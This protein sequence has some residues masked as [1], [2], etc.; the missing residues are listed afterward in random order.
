MSEAA[1]RTAYDE[2]PYPGYTHPQTHPDRLA[3]IATVF[4]MRPK[5]IEGCRVLEL[6]CGDG[7]NLIPMAFGLR[8]SEFVGLD[9][10]PTAIAK[11]RQA[12]EELGLKN[13]QLRAE[14][15]LAFPKEFGRFDYIIAHGLY[16]WVPREVRDA[17]LRICSE[18]L[19]PAGVAFVSYNAFP[20]GHL[21]HMLRDM[22]FFH[23][24][25]ISDSKGRLS[26]AMAL[27]RFMSRA[28]ENNDVYAR[29]LQEE[30]EQLI[31]RSAGHLYH[32]EL[33]SVY[34]PVY[35]HEFVGHAQSHGLQY[36]GEA[37]FMEMQD[38]LFTDETR[39]TLNGL[40]T[41]RIA[42]EQYLDFLKCRRFR[43]TLLC[44]GGV[45]LELE[46]QPLIVKRF[47]LSSVAKPETPEVN[48]TDDSVVK[49]VGKRIAS[50]E[51]NF[52]LAKAALA[53]LGEMWPDALPFNELIRRT[54][55]D[56]T[57]E[58][59]AALCDVL[60][61]TYRTG[62]L[63]LHVHKPAYAS[64]PSERPVASALARRQVRHGATV[65]NAWHQSVEIGDK[66]GK[67]LILLLDGSRERDALLKELRQLYAG[68]D[69]EAQ[70]E[71][72]LKTIG[73]L[74]LLVQ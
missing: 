68:A 66:I 5:A 50:I 3:T 6:G 69:L 36:L 53:L 41:N 64:A 70:L 15:I 54:G 32:D 29:F 43:Q 65:T 49:F 26:Q 38:H 44:H 37:D 62:L 35:F 8:E 58:R 24:Q 22:M 48:L 1:G 63:E 59:E 56:T 7:S 25:S 47:Y 55:M 13:I 12:I 28:R 16:S 46:P 11:G 27:V 61:Q 73:R 21:R 19:E 2:V 14:D 18:Q 42:W 17:A 71:R 31:E 57:S 10:A 52:P 20:G 30:F 51:T 4:G 34:E 67:H 74:G 9:L 40:A 72:N 33:S 39:A 23:V 60:F 45:G